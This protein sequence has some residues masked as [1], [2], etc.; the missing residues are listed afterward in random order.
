MLFL[1]LN[2][3]PLKFQISYFNCNIEINLTKHYLK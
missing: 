1:A 3:V 2:V